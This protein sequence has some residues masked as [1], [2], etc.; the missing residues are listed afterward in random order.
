[1][2]AGTNTI[3]FTSGALSTVAHVGDALSAFYGGQYVR[4]ADGTLDLTTTGFPKLSTTLGVI[5]DPNPDWRGGFGANA[6][7]KNFSFNILFETFQ[8][9][10]FY[11]GTRAVLVNFGTYADVGKE[12]T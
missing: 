12:V 11:E 6:S 5:G 7:Y 2:L 9:G 1:D 10:D 3:T 4:K 8:G